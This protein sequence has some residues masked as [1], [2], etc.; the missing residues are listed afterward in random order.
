MSLKSRLLKNR[1]LKSLNFAK[2]SADCDLLAFFREH[3][4]FDVITAYSYDKIYGEKNGNIVKI[5]LVFSSAEVYFAEIE[6]IARLYDYYLDKKNPKATISTPSNSIINIL[7]PPIVEKEP[8]IS[9]F[10]KNKQLYSSYFSTK[11][12]SSEMVAYFRDCIFQRANIFIVGDASV[13]K[14][15]LMNFMVNLSDSTKKNIICG[16]TEKI[17]VEKPCSIKLSQGCI[18][19]VE[20][21]NYDNIFYSDA[22]IADLTQIFQLIISGHNGFVVSMSLKEDV[23]ILTAI[24]NMIL[25]SNI[26]LFEENADFMTSASID[27]VVCVNK[28]NGEFCITK[29][30]EMVKNSQNDYSVKDIFVRNINGYHVSTGN[31]SRFFNPENSQ[32]FMREF[33]EEGHK[34]SYVSG[35]ANSVVANIPKTES[36]RKRLKEKLKKLK[37]EKFVLPVVENDENVSNVTV[38]ENVE[39][40]KASAVLDEQNIT[41]NPVE[42]V[43]EPVPQEEPLTFFGKPIDEAEKEINES[44]VTTD[45]SEQQ[46]IP[47]EAEESEKP[48]FHDVLEIS[49]N[50]GLLASAT[51]DFS[52]DLP[53][54][55]PKIKNILD[56]DD[57]EDEV[58]EKV[59]T[60]KEMV[61]GYDVSA[62]VSTLL[63]D[64]EYAEIEEELKNKYHDDNTEIV[65]EPQL[66]SEVSDDE[67]RQYEQGIIEVPDEDI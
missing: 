25:L 24:R 45:L 67:V 21:L 51:D 40:I 30:S 19:D 22:Q 8:F 44:A 9:I 15:S 5:P 12:V 60:P 17:I 7:I 4:E 52:Q 28:I 61:D 63:S 11:I 56:V 48:S 55:Q 18:K 27:V 35:Q 13:D 38:S 49:A 62:D 57:E 6:K 34:H 39:E 1:E 54:P 47:N 59:D 42:V 50:E 33:L 29:V 10:R 31:S 23:D 66:F 53:L 3:K 26:N 65:E 41:E 37:K 20:N 46:S 16:K 32:R 64:E 43:T 2:V 36:K 14:T 58:Q